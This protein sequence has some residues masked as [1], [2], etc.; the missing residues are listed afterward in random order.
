MDIFTTQ[1]T[2]VVPVTIKPE[3]L[4]VKAL[5]KDAR[6]RAFEENED[7]YDGSEQITI[8]PKKESEARH[9]STEEKVPD[10]ETIKK[11]TEEIEKGGDSHTVNNQEND[12]NDD[13]IHHLDI[14]V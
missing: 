13:D 2:R 6:V 4:K 5:V 8:N 7:H 3:K 1:L 14:F 11:I 12:D 10:T 9:Q